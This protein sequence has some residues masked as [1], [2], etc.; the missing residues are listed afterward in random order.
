M[1]DIEYRIAD[2]RQKLIPI[3]DIMADSALFSPI[4]DVPISGAQS[5]IA[6]HRYRTECPPM[7]S[8]TLPE[9]GLGHE[10]ITEHI[11]HKITFTYQQ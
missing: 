10:I 8:Y 9:V 3:F 7:G 5:D 2:I 6:D 1:S 4:S 11:L